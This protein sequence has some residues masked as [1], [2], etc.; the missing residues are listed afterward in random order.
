[1]RFPQ[2]VVYE[3]DDRLAEL[4]R[5]TALE[6]RWKLR[7]PRRSESCLRLLQLSGRR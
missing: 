5:P 6:R 4:L 1:M 2:I 7:Q 3:R